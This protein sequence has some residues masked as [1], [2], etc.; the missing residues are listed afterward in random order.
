M[1]KS[2]IKAI[3]LMT[4]LLLVWCCFS[5]CTQRKGKDA[6]LTEKQKTKVVET[7]DEEIAEQREHDLENKISN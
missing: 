6:D 3:L 2:N 1:T 4:A 7:I 5:S